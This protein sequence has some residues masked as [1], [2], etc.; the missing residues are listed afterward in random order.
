MCVRCYATRLHASETSD[1][2]PG[3]PASGMHCQSGPTI[4]LA[5]LPSVLRGKRCGWRRVSSFSIP[6]VVQ[7]SC[8]HCSIRGCIRLQFPEQ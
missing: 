4:P 2:L 3:F 6:L 1:V 7:L 5:L 8:T